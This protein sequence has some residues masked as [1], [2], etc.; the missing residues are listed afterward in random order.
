MIE[1]LGVL[2]LVALLTVVG[3]LGPIVPPDRWLVAGAVLTAVGLATGVP[4]GLGYHVAL[5]RRLR[6]HTS[7]PPRW[8]LDPVALHP[9][10]RERERRGVLTWFTLGGIGFA[11]VV[12]GCALCVLGLLLQ[13]LALGAP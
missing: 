11:V 4:T 13:W 9:E 8:W 7:L 1:T 12:L 5:Y 3:V 2:A 10:L 6:A